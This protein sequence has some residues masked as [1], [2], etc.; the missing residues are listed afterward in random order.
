MRSGNNACD[1][2]VL[3]R[4]TAVDGLRAIAALGVVW[5]HT[6]I[7]TGNPACPLSLGPW[8]VNLQ[9]QLVLL[10]NGFN[11][12]FVIS[13]FCLCLSLRGRRWEPFAP[14]FGRFLAQRWLR[15]APVYYVA[16]VAGALLLCLRT[17]SF[18]WHSL[19]THLCFGQLSLPESEILAAQFWTLQTEWEFYLVLPLMLWSSSRG[20]RTYAWSILVVCIGSL[21]FRYSII[22]A[23]TRVSPEWLSHLPFRFVEFAWGMIAAELVLAGRLPPR[24]LSGTTGVFFALM[25]AYVGRG[26]MTTEAA[27]IAAEYTPIVRTFA[28]PVLTLGFAL[29][30]WNVATVTSWFTILLTTRI[31]QVIGQLSYG[32]Y[33]WH[34][35]P[36]TP[37]ARWS[38]SQFGQTVVAHYV[39][40]ILVLLFLLPLSWLTFRLLEHPFIKMKNK[41]PS[42][43]AL[44][45]AR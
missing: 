19:V 10:G 5:W 25:I 31:L 30:I 23:S 3:R 14:A 26:M 27:N 36:I 21:F 8:T 38:T 32:I 4:I 35:W 24:L 20:R 1:A 42:S 16:C 11:L 41:S 40:L 34:W 13:G 43:A 37:L 44:P 29:L 15:L 9:R 22:A 17:G 7:A 33:L 6:W 12:F 39:T 28:E 18:P 45:F 2:T